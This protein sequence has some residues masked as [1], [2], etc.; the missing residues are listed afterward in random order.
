MYTLTVNLDCPTIAE[1][2]SKTEDQLRKMRNENLKRYLIGRQRQKVLKEAVIAA[3][4]RAA[5]AWINL[6]RM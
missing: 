5:R 2:H 1:M 4:L 3:E 6:R